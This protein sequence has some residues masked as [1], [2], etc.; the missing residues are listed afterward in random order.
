MDDLPVCIFCGALSDNWWY[1]DG[2]VNTCRCR[3]CY[4]NGTAETEQELAFYSALSSVPVVRQEAFT[5]LH[6]PTFDLSI[7][8]LHIEEGS[9]RLHIW[10][11]RNA[12][13]KGYL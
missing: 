13:R 5:E 3:E 10:A 2:K 4:D 7:W 9:E 11:N 6:S 1:L 12:K 8:K